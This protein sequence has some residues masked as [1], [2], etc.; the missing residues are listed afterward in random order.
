MSPRERGQSCEPGQAPDMFTSHLDKWSATRVFGAWQAG[1]RARSGGNPGAGLRSGRAGMSWGQVGCRRRNSRAAM[2]DRAGAV[3]RV[4]GR[5]R[6]R[7]TWTGEAPGLAAGPGWGRSA[8]DEQASK[9]CGFPAGQ[10]R[11]GPVVVRPLW[12]DGTGDGGAGKTGNDG[13]E[14]DPG[15]G[16]TLA[17]CLMHA[18]RT[19]SPSGGSRGGRV[20]NTW[21]ICP[22][23]G[24]SPR[25][26]GV[27]PYVL[28]S[29]VG[30]ISKGPSGPPVEEAAAD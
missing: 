24:G 17:A 6:A 20:R 18:S 26:R 1:V 16:S 12:G 22:P 23:A 11:R 4:A 14:F 15:S 9:R 10:A 2:G 28:A 30:E 25:K 27:I 19:G 8:S 29:R 21:P 3:T 5:T 7:A 13:G